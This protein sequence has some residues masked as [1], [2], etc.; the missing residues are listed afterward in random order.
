M[1]LSHEPRMPLILIAEDDED[2]R[3]LAAEAIARAGLPG[4]VK[5]FEDGVD[6]M[7]HLR[8]VAHVIERDEIA[9]DREIILLD[10]NMPRKDGWSVLADLKKD[11][12]L[13]A[14]PVILLT[15][16]CSQTD[17]ERGYRMGASSFITKPQSFAGLV[18]LVSEVNRYWFGTVRLPGNAS[19]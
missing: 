17:V 18:E 5:F 4:D 1:N 13:R 6:L 11:Q 3:M 12:R 9:M 10:I 14:I 2:D 8:S 16:S 7:D 19:C 15:T